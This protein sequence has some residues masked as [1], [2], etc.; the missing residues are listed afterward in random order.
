MKYVMLKKFPKQVHLASIIIIAK[1]N[2][3]KTLILL[4]LSL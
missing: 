3:I 4:V 2:L 1:S